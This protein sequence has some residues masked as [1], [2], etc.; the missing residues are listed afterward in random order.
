MTKLTAQEQVLWEL[1]DIE[2]DDV[3]I[4][5]LE[6]VA[7]Y[8]SIGN[9][10]VDTLAVKVLSQALVKV[11]A[12]ATE[13]S[14]ESLASAYVRVSPMHADLVKFYMLKEKV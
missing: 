13:K 9:D 10:H 2:S 4:D 6:R 12:I 14:G 8:G 7:P 11:L 5:L 3:V 1:I